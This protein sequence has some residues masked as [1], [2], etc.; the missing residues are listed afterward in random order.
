MGMEPPCKIPRHG[1]R[2][3]RTQHISRTCSWFLAGLTGSP[4]WR[5]RAPPDGAA[6]SRCCASWTPRRRWHRT[7]TAAVA[8][9][10]LH[11]IESIESPCARHARHS[12]PIAT[13]QQRAPWRPRCGTAWSC[14]GSYRTPSAPRSRRTPPGCSRWL[15]AS[16][17]N[18]PN[19]R[20]LRHRRR[21]DNQGNHTL[22]SGK[23]DGTNTS[24]HGDVPA[25]TRHRAQQPAAATRAPP[26]TPAHAPKNN[27]PSA[28][29][30]SA[31]VTMR[32][33]TKHSV[34]H[35]GGDIEAFRPLP[36]GIYRPSR[37]SRTRHRHSHGVTTAGQ[38][39]NAS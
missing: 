14:S 26:H 20:F 36:T 35:D 12:A 28:V 16:H 17:R 10:Q 24:P 34:S 23:R 11:D 5:C 31:F 18:H 38:P 30:L 29:A 8:P 7:V 32:S 37:T 19:E 15:A 21:G 22:V 2:C 27:R 3:R 33:P 1:T 6:R 25:R 4:L 39:G 13:P 9:N